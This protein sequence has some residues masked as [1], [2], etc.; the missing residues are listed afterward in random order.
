MN[1]LHT[2]FQVSHILFEYG[3]LFHLQKIHVFEWMFPAKIINGTV[4]TILNWQSR[5]FEE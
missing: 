4:P 1:S 5:I 3:P 2:V